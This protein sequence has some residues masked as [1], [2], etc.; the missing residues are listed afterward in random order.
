MKKLIA[1]A[2]PIG[3]SIV[4]VLGILIEDGIY[5]QLNAVPLAVPDKYD[6][7]TVLLCVETDILIYLEECTYFFNEIVEWCNNSGQFSDPLC[8]KERL[9]EFFSSIEKIK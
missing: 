9:N 1:I 7:E 3:I 6:L 2:I 5:Q 4:I 8:Q